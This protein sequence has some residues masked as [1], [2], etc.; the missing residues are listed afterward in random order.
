MRS[1]HRNGSRI[2]TRLGRWAG[3]SQARREQVRTAGPLHLGDERLALCVLAELGLQ[4]DQLLEQPVEAAGRLAALVQDPTEPI[5]AGHQALAGA[6]H[7]D[8]AM[9]LE[10]AHQPPTW[11]STARCSGPAKRCTSPP[12]ASGF[13]PAR[14][15]VGQPADGVE[16]PL[17]IG[18]DGAERSGGRDRGSAGRSHGTPVNWARWVTS[19]SASHSRNSSGGKAKRFSRASTFGPDVV[20]DVLVLGVLLLDDQQVVL[21]EDP[22]RHPAEQHAQLGPGA[23]RVASGASEPVPTRSSSRSSS[24]R[25]SRW[26]EDDVGPD[27]SGAV[28]D[29]GP[30]RAGERAQAGRRPRPGPRPGRSAR[31]KSGCE[32]GEW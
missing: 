13:R 24:G 6:V 30:G 19:C 23:R 22:G 27:P 31:S 14:I 3:A 2:S 16:Q 9:A 32:G 10:Q 7:G 4:P 25:S 5:G 21:A 8:V 17:R 1:I 18:I 12:S 11:S 29:P 26:N 28:G 15:G 20:D